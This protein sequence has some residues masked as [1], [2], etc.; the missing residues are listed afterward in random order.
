MC[1]LMWRVFKKE[2][3]GY[4]LIVKEGFEKYYIVFKIIFF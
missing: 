2:L 1:I 4:D 3:Q